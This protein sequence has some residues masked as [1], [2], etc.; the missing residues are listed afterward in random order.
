[1]KTIP[2]PTSSRNPQEALGTVRRYLRHRKPLEGVEGVFA[3]VILAVACVWAFWRAGSG[4]PTGQPTPEPATRPTLTMIMPTSAPVPFLAEI[5]PDEP[6]VGLPLDPTPT[7]VDQWALDVVPPP[8]P[9]NCDNEVA[10]DGYRVPDF[11]GYCVPGI[12]SRHTL[13]IQ[14]PR[15]FYG[16]LSSYGPYA[17]ELMEDRAGVRRGHGVALTTCGMMGYTAWLRLPGE[18][19]RGPFTVVDCGAQAH[20]FYQ[21]AVQGLAVEVGYTVGQTW[22]PASSRVD[23]RLG[24]Y[25]GADWDGL[26]LAHWWVDNALRWETGYPLLQSIITRTD[27]T[28]FWWP[29]LE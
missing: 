29:P 27:G 1:M 12:L 13:N 24:S 11:G 10:W 20:T 3:V 6:P 23:V 2:E 19:W 21:I 18:A 28:T 25:P 8:W 16:T 22:T 14:F 5:V 9:V 4:L 26:Y 17:M 7:P 15:S